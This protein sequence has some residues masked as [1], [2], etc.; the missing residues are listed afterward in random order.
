ML[1]TL[2]GNLELS[3]G[4]AGY[5]GLLAWVALFWIAACP[6]ASGGPTGFLVTISKMCNVPRSAM[7]GG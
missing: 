3:I 4:V 1:L 5:G 7:N 6:V 2:A